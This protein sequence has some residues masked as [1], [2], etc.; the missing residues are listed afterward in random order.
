MSES[1]PLSTTINVPSVP[2]AAASASDFQTSAPNHFLK[3]NFI[4]WDVVPLLSPTD[5]SSF[6]MMGLVILGLAKS[7]IC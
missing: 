7:L 1:K 5:A 6:A 2:G 3:A 4:V